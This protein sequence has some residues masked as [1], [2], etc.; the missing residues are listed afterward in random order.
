MPHFKKKIEYNLY[1]INVNDIFYFNIVESKQYK[2]VDFVLIQIF[3]KIV[4]INI[5]HIESGGSERIT[6]EFK[7]ENLRDK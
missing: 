2:N 7:R 1:I 3:F 4:L 6:L 5:G